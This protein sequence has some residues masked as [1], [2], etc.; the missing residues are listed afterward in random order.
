MSQRF[1]ITIA[2]EYKDFPLDELQTL[3]AI[4][5]IRTFLEVLGFEATINIDPSDSND[6]P[7]YRISIAVEV[8]RAH[9]PQFN[10][11]VRIEYDMPGKT[12]SWHDF[13]RAAQ[14]KDM[15][16][17]QIVKDLQ[18]LGYEINCVVPATTTTS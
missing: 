3:S 14:A 1:L 9:F 18:Y 15:L 11:R 12:G 2:E 16:M 8:N 7:E 6:P 4:R 10:T 13:C 5:F 17:V